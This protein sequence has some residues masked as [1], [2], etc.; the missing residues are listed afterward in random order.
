MLRTA[1]NGYNP[2]LNSISTPDLSH[3]S[4]D[5]SDDL[6]CTLNSSCESIIF[7]DN[8]G[9]FT[10]EAKEALVPC[11][12]SFVLDDILISNNRT[13]SLLNP[14]NAHNVPF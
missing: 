5:F 8:A 12:E 2:I 9:V 10:S 3:C 1:C 11:T 13:D 14:H 6:T 7:D 4:E